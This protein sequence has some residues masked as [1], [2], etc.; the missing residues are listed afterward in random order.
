[1]SPNKTMKAVRL[2]EFGGPDKL[3]YEDQPVPEV[4]R[5]DV[6]V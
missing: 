5:G 6:L 3:V 2:Y 4:G 1:M